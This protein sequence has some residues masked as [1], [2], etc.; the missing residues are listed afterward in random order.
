MKIMALLGFCLMAC[1]ATAADDVLLEAERQLNAGEAQAAFELL[2]PLQT[3]RAGDPDYDYLLGWAALQLGRDTEAV[4]ALER[5]LA[6]QPD[7]TEAR[8]LIARAYFNL[9]ET[10]SAKKEFE[11]VKQQDVPPEVVK[12]IDRFLAA[13]TRIEDENRVRINGYMETGFGFDSNVNA[14]TSDSQIAVP[15]QGGAILNLSS[16]STKR[17]DSYLSLG[18]RLNFSAPLKNAL[19]LFGGVGF[20]R[21]SNRDETDFSTYYYDVDL[22]LSYKRDRETFTIAASSNEYFIESPAYS[23]S[24][25]N[26]YGITGNWQHDFDA[27]NQMSAFLETTNLIYPDQ[28][29][30]N[31]HR[32]V[33]GLAYAHATQSSVVG[34]AGA[35]VGSEKVKDNNFEE[36]GNRFF[37]IRLGGQKSVGDKRVFFLNAS[38]ERRDYG[39]PDPDF[40]VNRADDQMNASVGM[41][42]MPRR[43]IR[44]IPQLT[45][46]RNDSNIRFDEFNRLTVSLMY[47]QDM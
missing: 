42:Y 1:L 4:F 37:G 30:R 44:L 27:R 33:A 14:A 24:Y 20:F 8:A 9:K 41:S 34:Y 7:N 12:T 22:G 11:N 40:S 18:G 29:A 32:Y 26:S 39:G 46:T 3:E 38:A 45:Y 2:E 36:F 19:S 6:V 28:G 35:Y 25:R 5:V 43:D 10:D 17:S 16:D 47:R 13:I 23:T 31:A 21:K 15:A